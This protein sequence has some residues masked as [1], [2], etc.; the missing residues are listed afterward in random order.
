MRLTTF[1]SNAGGLKKVFSFLGVA[2]IFLVSMGFGSPAEASVSNGISVD[3]YSNY[4]Q[5]AGLQPFESGA[6][7]S[8]LT[9]CRSATISQINWDRSDG[10]FLGCGSNNVLVHYT[11]YLRNPSSNPRTYYFWGWSD[12]GFWAKVGGTQVVNAWMDKGGSAARVGGSSVSFDGNEFK[13]IDI[14]YFDSGGGAS[15]VF[16]S[17]TTG[18]TPGSA[19]S[20]VI[21][22]SMYTLDNYDSVSFT[23][24]AVQREIV[25]GSNVSTAVSATA[26]GAVTYA[27]SSGTLPNGLTLSSSS[28]TI[29]GSPTV[30]GTYTFK[31]RATGNDAGTI[32]QATTPDLTMVVGSTT[33][34]TED[35]TVG[36]GWIGEPVTGRAIFGG[37]PSP[38]VS[39]GSGSLP[40]GVSVSANGTLSGNATQSGTYTFTLKGT[41]FADPAGT[42]TPSHTIVIEAAPDFTADSGYTQ[43]IN[44]G[45]AYETYTPTATGR[46]VTYT[47]E[48]GTNLPAGLTLNSATGR[49][50]G[51]PTVA[52]RFVFRVVATNRSGRNFSRSSTITVRQ[53]PIFT[54]SNVLGG[55]PRDSSYQFDFDASGFP[56]PTYSVTSG[57]LP[58]GMS[59]NGTSGLLSGTPNTSGRFEF[60]IR[61]L[62]DGGS[63]EITKVLNVNQAPRA[64]DT[65]LLERLLV[66]SDYRDQVVYDSFPAPTYRVSEGVLPPGLML[67]TST[68]WLTGKATTGGQYSFK[69]GVS[70]GTNSSSTGSFNFEVSQAPTKSDDTILATTE[71]GKPY[72]DGILTIGYPVPSYELTSGSLPAGIKLNAATGELIGTPTATGTYSFTVSAK[73]SVGTLAHLLTLEVQQAPQNV[74]ITAPTDAGVGEQ[75]SGKVTATGF[76]AP[77][78]A[79]TSGALPDGVSL[80]ATTGDISG[81]IANGGNFSYTISA[82]NAIGSMPGNTVLVEVLGVKSE[83]G[84]GVKIGDEITG[85]SIA[86]ASEGLKSNAPYSVVLRSTPQTIASGNTSAKGKVSEQA[87]IPGGLEPGWHSITLTS[88]N[89]DGSAFE[90]AIYFQ[91]TETLLLE[92]IRESEPS[93]ADKAEALT[94][95]PEFY[96]RMGLDPAATVTPA[97]AAAQVEQVTSVVASVALVSAAAAGAAAAA[98]AAGGAASSAG[99]SSGGGS[100]GGARSSGGGSS[101]SSSSSGGGTNSDGSSDDS[102]GDYG[103]LE[104]EHDDFETEG[105]GFVDRLKIWNFKWL[106]ALDKPMTNWIE[107]SAQVSPV[108]SRILNDGS[109]LR[110]LVGSVMGL[111]YLIALVL[112]VAAVDIGA[113]S[114]AASGRVGILVAIMAF[115]TLDALFGVVAMSA[116]VITS[117][118]S[119]PTHGVGDI[120]YLLAMFIL[121][122]AP[123]I[124]ATTFRKIRRPAIESLDEAWERLID[125]A[126]IGFISVLTVM[127]LVGSVSAFAGAT[128]PIG[129]DVKPIALAIASVA[130]MRVLLEEAAAKFAPD[131]LNRINPTEVP[132]TF[133]WQPWASLVLKATVLVLMIGGM[134]GMGWHLWVGTFLI[135]LPGIIGMVFPELPS[136]K[137]IH[138]FIPGGVGALAFATLISSW[139]GQI[140][141]ALLGKSELY[142]QL[143]FI[144]IPLPVILIAIIGMFAKQEDKL[145]QRTNKKWLYIAGGIA[146]FVFTIQVTDF[147]PTI[148]S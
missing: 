130:L 124:M 52:G 117:L 48:T 71:I 30:A 139:S 87:K 34:L 144:L 147:F 44:I 94:N 45:D 102:G 49:I 67:N 46:S 93:A 68:G 95:D 125:L 127:S 62:N 35:I 120:R 5:G 146:V 32:S 100:S 126:L 80:D 66:G 104:A 63:V 101:S 69:I 65:S 16:Q 39:V 138:E 11:G 128:V 58:T 1:K 89:P 74:K 20:Y 37:Y 84:L 118:I 36:G 26:T 72:S 92:E 2:L 21:P 133:A 81:T 75:Y 24:T 61:A 70:N 129:A 106:T 10:S 134:V 141:N 148:F 14:W 108:L 90:K 57:Y 42:S 132:G 97:A 27:V 77:T 51:T 145:W 6:N 76:P 41:N 113:S 8:N 143:S 131:R 114:M 99:G 109:Y 60:T 38:S 4:T 103:N 105:A 53:A 25:L 98:S 54:K 107:K 78:F 40:P 64:V 50:S 18:A 121:G 15:S 136:F 135:F 56:A 13:T 122:F 19:G 112:G 85:K 83:L 59:L 82:T 88:M 116:F 7:L 9:L 115:G 91:V 17:N 137:W 140:V 23:D 43:A 55:I 3:I 111:T 96:A 110:S 47:L 142:G 73:N 22:A 119:M 29:T 123:S 33:S 31:I 86:I 28:G 79:V 12:D